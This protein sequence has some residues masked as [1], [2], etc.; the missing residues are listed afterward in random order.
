MAG[1]LFISHPSPE[2]HR[3]IYHRPMII[4]YIIFLLGISGSYSRPDARLAVKSY[5][6]S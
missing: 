4:I 1:N 2:N 3:L 5:F 6:A